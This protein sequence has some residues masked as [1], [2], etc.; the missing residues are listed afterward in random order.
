VAR[1]LVVDD[2]REIVR[3][4]A[5]FLARLGHVVA[6]AHSGAEALALARRRRFDAVLLD[7]LMPGMDGNET[8]RRL[9]ALDPGAVVI[10]ISGAADEKASEES[11]ALGAF[12][13]IRKPFDFPH[14]ETVLATALAMRA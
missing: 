2:E 7:I 9:R 5:E 14:L 8:L 13:Y 11:L 1:V 10:M 4:L 6:E 12:D 3:M